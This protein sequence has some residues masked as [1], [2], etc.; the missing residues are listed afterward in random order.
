MQVVFISQCWL[1]TGDHTSLSHLPSLFAMC[2]LCRSPNTSIAKQARLSWFFENTKDPCDQEKL[3]VLI[4]IVEFVVDLPVSL[5]TQSIVLTQV[6]RND[7]IC[8]II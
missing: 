6:L 8:F 7:A 2:F 1:G 3:R 4:G 5:G